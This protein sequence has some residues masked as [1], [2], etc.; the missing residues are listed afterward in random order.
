MDNQYVVL[1]KKTL[2][3]YSI[4]DNSKLGEANIE[5]TPSGKPLGLNFDGISANGLFH[6]AVSYSQYETIHPKDQFKKVFLTLFTVDHANYKLL[7]LAEAKKPVDYGVTWDLKLY[8]TGGKVFVGHLGSDGLCQ[9]A[10]LLNNNEWNKCLQDK[11]I[12]Y[13]GLT[14]VDH[15]MNYFWGSFEALE[16]RVKN[17]V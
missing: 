8:T 9:S 14:N 13:S 7:S 15:M 3:F 1:T 16:S 6:F 17:Q 12:Q 4:L 2:F 11:Y 10:I 5:V